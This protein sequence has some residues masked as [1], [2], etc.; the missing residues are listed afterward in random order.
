MMH[1]DWLAKYPHVAALLQGAEEELLYDADAARSGYAAYEY[2]R[3][4]AVNRH[5]SAGAIESEQAYEQAVMEYN[6]AYARARRGLL[7]FHARTPWPPQE[8]E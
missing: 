6:Q 4:M 1:P 3:A 2:E 7:V 8:F 5:A